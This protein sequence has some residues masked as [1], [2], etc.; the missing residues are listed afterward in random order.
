MTAAKMQHH[1]PFRNFARPA[2]DTLLAFCKRRAE[3]KKKK[4]KATD[5]FSELGK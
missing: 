2:V 1:S 4:E 3:S 5:G